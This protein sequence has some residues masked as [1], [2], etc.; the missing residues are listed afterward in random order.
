MS[1]STPWLLL[2]ALLPVSAVS[3]AAPAIGNA[4]PAIGNVVAEVR[5]PPLPAAVTSLAPNLE[6]KGGGEMTFMTLSVYAAYFY[7]VDPA[8]CRW[9]PE[10]P[11]AMQLVYHRSLVGAKIAER[12]VE[13][14]TK[15]GYGTPEQRARWGEQM[16]QFFVDVV[17]GDHIT[18]VNLPQIGVRYYYNGKLLGEILDREFAKAFFAI[19]LDPR[20]SE[21]ELRKKLLG[22]AQ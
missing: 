3:S 8:R 10:Q 13:E 11:F 18:G 5:A 1:R 17:G 15:L 20:T 9:S 12:S 21:P 7:C 14:I 22:E 19:W 6:A 2:S 16:K 4:V